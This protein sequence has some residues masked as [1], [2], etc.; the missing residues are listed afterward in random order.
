MHL[1]VLYGYQGADAQQLAFEQLFDAASGELGVVV[2][3]QPCMLVGDFNVEP[4][5]I[6]LP[7]KRDF[8]WALG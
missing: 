2:R 5:K 4:T 3:G 7:G 1:V 8:C 6:P